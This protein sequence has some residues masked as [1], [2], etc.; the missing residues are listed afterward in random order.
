MVLRTRMRST[1]EVQ[2]EG[3]RAGPHPA[4]LRLG[5]PK[6]KSGKGT[7]TIHHRFALLRDAEENCPTFR[8]SLAF[9]CCFPTLQNPGEKP[10]CSVSGKE[11]RLVACR[12][13]PS[14]K[15]RCPET[16][17]RFVNG[18]KRTKSRFRKPSHGLAEA[19]CSPDLCRDPA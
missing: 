10:S 2:V 4:P 11:S 19:G 18:V 6:A 16:G 15:R 17:N 7:E 1:P 14:R 8:P 3:P 5:R 12:P 9:K 13:T